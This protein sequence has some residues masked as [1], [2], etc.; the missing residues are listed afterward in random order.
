[1]NTPPRVLGAIA[2]VLS[3]VFA[4]VASAVNT[5]QFAYAAGY[6]E[7]NGI[8]TGPGPDIYFVGTLGDEH[9]CY[10]VFDLADIG[11][12]VQ[13]A[14]ISIYTPHNGVNAPNGS[15]L[16][17]LFDVSSSATNVAAGASSVS[18]FNDLGSGTI[19]GSRIY[20][21]ADEQ[22][23]ATIPLNAA[24][25][26]QINSQLGQ[27]FAIGGAIVPAPV[28]VAY[29]FGFSFLG[30]PPSNVYLTLNVVPEPAMIGM[31]PLLVLAARRRSS[32]RGR[33]NAA[34]KSLN[35]R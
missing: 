8:A 33:S 31:T 24:A 10:F 17:D 5:T 13:D 22:N 29:T 21:E 20:T 1:V 7:P 27:S 9:R 15:L 11:P 16:F 6:Y 26:A 19:Y 32:R 4:H 18:I 34:E 12:I 14:S 2:L 30:N 35:I 25:V 23:F 3:L 28:D